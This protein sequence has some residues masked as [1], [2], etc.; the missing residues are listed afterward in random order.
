M[1]YREEKR[2][3]YVSIPPSFSL[4]FIFN[5]EA[6]EEVWKLHNSRVTSCDDFLKS[7]SPNLREVKNYER[8]DR[9]AQIKRSKEQ[10]FC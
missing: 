10:S 1:K 2:K 7:F 8:K 6:R 4:L 9:M 5:R 3:E